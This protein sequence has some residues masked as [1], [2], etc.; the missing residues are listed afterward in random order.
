MGAMVAKIISGWSYTEAHLGNMFAAL[1]GAKMPVAVDMYASLR[2]FDAQR[3]LLN[4]TSRKLLPKRYADVVAAT[5]T[6]IAH[7]AKER[8]KFAHWIWG[9]SADPSLSDTLLLAEP[10]IF[11][12]NRAAQVRHWN[13]TKSKVLRRAPDAFVYKPGPKLDVNQ[14]YLYR[15]R[16]LE[17]INS[18][19]ELAYSLA[20]ALYELCASDKSRRPAVYRWLRSQEEVSKALKK[21]TNR[22]N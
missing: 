20:H 9:R 21:L 7:T 1:I 5:I 14:A 8:H 18:R 2:T 15:M 17:D 11:W 10:S 6:V 13:K 12:K 16:D 4:A 19:M 3:K 22:P